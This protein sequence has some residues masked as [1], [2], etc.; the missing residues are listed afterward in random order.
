[1]CFDRSGGRET[2][3][4]RITP[5]MCCRALFAVC[6][7]FLLYGAM[8]MLFDGHTR[9]ISVCLIL[10]FWPLHVAILPVCRKHTSWCCVVLLVPLASFFWGRFSSRPLCACRHVVY[11]YTSFHTRLAVLIDNPNS[12]HPI[13]KAGS[14]SIYVYLSC[15]YHLKSIAWFM[16]Y[17]LLGLCNCL[18]VL[19]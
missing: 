10:P 6:T 13:L 1:M 9:Y 18:S 11:S 7:I 3:S 17:L 12:L 8:V 16:M 4:R 2:P 5:K 14:N 15:K 19:I